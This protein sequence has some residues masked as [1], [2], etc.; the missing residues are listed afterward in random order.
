MERGRQSIC[1]TTFDS[2]LLRFSC[3]TS[4]WGRFVEVVFRDFESDQDKRNKTIKLVDMMDS[5]GILWENMKP[6][7]KDAFDIM[8]TL[9][10]RDKSLDAT[11]I[12]IVSHVL[13]DP[14][15]KFFFTTN[16]NILENADIIDLEKYL[17]TN[18]KRHVALKTSN[19]F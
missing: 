3:R 7:E 18:G 9:S 15:S 16:N 13:S 8:V 1:C 14:D 12:M 4:F 11:D 19:G 6:A 17:N 5:N 10:G 2:M